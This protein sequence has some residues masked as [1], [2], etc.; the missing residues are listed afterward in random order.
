M[1]NWLNDKTVII[2]GASGGIGFSIAKTLIEK[3]NCKIIGIA[4]NEEKLLK[5]LESLGDKKANFSYCLFDVSIKENWI[6]FAKNLEENNIVPDVLINN[7]GFMLPFTKAENLSFDEIEKITNTNFLSVVYSTKTLLPLI[8]KSK[9]PAIIN[10]SSAAGVSAVVGQ[11]MYTGTKYAVRGYTQ[12]LEVENKKM[13][14]AGIYP[15]FIKTYILKGANGENNNASII[16]KMSTPLKKATNKI[17]R[18]IKKKRKNIVLGFGGKFLN[19]GGKH[20]PTFTSKIM[21]FVLRKA[22]LEMMKDL[23]NE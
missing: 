3:F 17:I 6:N 22:K 7:A 20:F 11:S 12:T 4:R 15:G 2:S 10:V 1:K 16:E 19:F 21:A 18:K 5:N 8:K 14:I 23:F 9:T 13:Y